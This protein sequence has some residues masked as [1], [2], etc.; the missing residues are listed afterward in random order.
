MELYLIRHTTPDITKGLCYGQS[1]LDTTDSFEQEARCIKPHLPHYISHV[2]S[3][4]LQRCRKLAEYLFPAQPI[5]FDDRLK[6][7]NCGSWEMKLWDE[8]DKQHLRSWM[9]DFVH[10]SMPGG[11]SYVDLYNR[12]VQFLQSLPQQGAIALVAHGGVIRSILSYIEQITLHES[13]NAFSLRYGCV[14]RVNR[15]LQTPAYAVLHNPPAEQE[16]HRPS[17][18]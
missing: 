4:P 10:T 11:E 13:F 3:S 7:I 17:Y 5:V 1:D 6:E 15:H 14:V 8:I 18:Y 9:D 16:Q 12:V 2:F